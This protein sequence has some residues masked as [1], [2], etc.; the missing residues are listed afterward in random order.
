MMHDRGGQVLLPAGLAA[1]RAG[2]DPEGEVREETVDQCPDQG[3]QPGAGAVPVIGDAEGGLAEPPQ[4]IAGEPDAQQ[5]QRDQAV[6]LAGQQLQGALLVRLVRALAERNQDRD[7][8]DEDV[9]DPARGEARP[10]QCPCRGA[11]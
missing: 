10:G 5:P 3:H 8:A 4:R 9:E 7:P 6:G 2:D 11:V 1:A